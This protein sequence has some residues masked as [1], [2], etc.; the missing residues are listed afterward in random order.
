MLS[1]QDLPAEVVLCSKDFFSTSDYNYAV[2]GTPVPVQ[3]VGKTKKTISRHAN[4]IAI[5]RSFLTVTKTYLHFDKADQAT[6]EKV[7]DLSSTG[8]TLDI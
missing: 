3:H 6:V 1:F 4:L 5:D 2:Y 8:I 7:V